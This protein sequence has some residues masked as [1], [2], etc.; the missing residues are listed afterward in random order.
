[1]AQSD[2]KIKFIDLRFVW[3]SFYFRYTVLL[4]RL[5]IGVCTLSVLLG[6]HKVILTLTL[7]N[8]IWPRISFICSSDSIP[9][10]L[11]HY[12][13]YSGLSMDFQCISRFVP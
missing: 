4:Y 3:G 6:C 12:P 2:K 13:G 10:I 5:M 1:M 7:S 9:R 8:P 11:N